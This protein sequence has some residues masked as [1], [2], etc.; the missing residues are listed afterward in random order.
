MRKECQTEPELRQLIQKK[1]NFILY[2]G[3]EPCMP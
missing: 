1:P 3:F 2:D